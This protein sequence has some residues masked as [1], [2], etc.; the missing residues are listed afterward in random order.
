M[1]K[2]QNF[3]IDF[4]LC[5]KK[6]KKLCIILINR[7]FERG[8]VRL[9]GKVGLKPR[10]YAC[11]T[12]EQ[13]E[14]YEKLPL[15]QRL[16]VDFRGEGNSK[17]NSYKMAGF[18]GKTAGQ[19][20]YLLEQRNE[21]IAELVKCVQGQNKVAQLS[22]EDSAVNQQIDA[23][24]LQDGAEKMMEVIEGADGETAKRIKFYRDVMN[25][26]VKTVRKT[27]KYNAMGALIETKV[28]EISDVD[29]KMRARKELDR[30]LGLNQL[31][32]LSKL[33]VGDITINIVDAS[34]KEELAD[35]R[36][37]VELDHN[38]V[39]VINGEQVIVEQEIKETESASAKFFDSVGE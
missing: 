20:A 2:G 39:Q 15:R 8:S 1:G 34:K 21:I 14:A 38:N 32:D 12:K 33:Q 19:A 28:E 13:Q 31:P 29:V 5:C 6:I 30:I 7:I 23:L 17:T 25:G 27:M 11:F 22:Q 18:D 4:K 36:N 24:A 16:Y 3:G 35:S 10:K 37:I 9:M 26:K